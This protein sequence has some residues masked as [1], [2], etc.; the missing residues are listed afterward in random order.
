MDRVLAVAFSNKVEPSA[1]LRQVD[2][3]ARRVPGRLQLRC[4]D[5][6]HQAFWL[7]ASSGHSCQERDVPE[8]V[9]INAAFGADLP[10]PPPYSSKVSR[11]LTLALSGGAMLP[12]LRCCVTS[13]RRVVRISSFSSASLHLSLVQDAQKPCEPNTIDGCVS[14]SDSSL[15]TVL[16][17]QSK[18]MCSEA[19]KEKAS[20]ISPLTEEHTGVSTKEQQGRDEHVE[21]GS[22]RRGC[23]PY[24]DESERVRGSSFRELL[25]E[26]PG[27]LQLSQCGG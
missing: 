26:K 9:R 14:P 21:Q 8:V 2:V 16:T 18:R 25:T 4:N 7:T 23:E 10:R 6:R 12:N 27:R 15:A 22:L 19:T 20:V 13:A 11:G 17:R 5:L 1:S 24:L 3:T